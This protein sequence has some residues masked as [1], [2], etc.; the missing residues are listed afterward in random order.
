MAVI[1]HRGDGDA[2]LELFQ[3]RARRPVAAIQQ[4][5]VGLVGVHQ[6]LKTGF[7]ASIVTWNPARRMGS[8]ASSLPFSAK[9]AP[10]PSRSRKARARATMRLT[11]P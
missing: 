9:T 3:F 7:V 10:M 4:Q 5:H 11:W 6:G 1:D 2:A 8:A